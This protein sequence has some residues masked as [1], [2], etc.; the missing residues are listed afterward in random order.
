MG[1]VWGTGMGIG[2]LGKNQKLELNLIVILTK[3]PI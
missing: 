1:V 2:A 3:S